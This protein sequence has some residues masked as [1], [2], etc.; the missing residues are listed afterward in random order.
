MS[1]NTTQEKYF[2]FQGT[3]YSLRRHLTLPL[4][5]FLLIFYFEISKNLKIGRFPHTHTHTHINKKYT[6]KRKLRIPL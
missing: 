2:S 1:V 3:A 4:L 5:L 6:F